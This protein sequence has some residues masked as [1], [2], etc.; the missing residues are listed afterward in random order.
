MMLTKPHVRGGDW[1][2]SRAHPLVPAGKGGTE[3]R[4]AWELRAWPHKPPLGLEVGVGGNTWDLT[5]RT[6]SRVGPCPTSSSGR[7]LFPE[8]WSPPSPW[9][10]AFTGG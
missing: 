6:V 5:F 3:Q 1:D 2:M 9:A 10:S 7:W 4:P 8:A